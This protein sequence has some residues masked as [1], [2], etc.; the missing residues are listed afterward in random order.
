M[1]VL[2]FVAGVLIGASVAVLLSRLRSPGD[3]VI[4]HSDPDCPYPFLEGKIPLQML[5]KRK[6]IMLKVVLRNYLSHK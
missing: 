1:G 2:Y 4:D 5:E 6:Y 3:L